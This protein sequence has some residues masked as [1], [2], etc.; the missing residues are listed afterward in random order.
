MQNTDLSRTS[1]SFEDGVRCVCGAVLGAVSFGGM[2]GIP[3]VLGASMVLVGILVGA[4]AGGVLAI[5][6]GELVWPPTLTSM[7]N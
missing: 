5:R 2:L 6:F 3:G 4:T 7:D 1:D